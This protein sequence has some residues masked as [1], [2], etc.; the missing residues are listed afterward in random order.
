MISKT[1][2][3][4]L[5]Y[6][7][8]DWKSAE[9]FI[10]E[11]FWAHST[12]YMTAGDTGL[13]TCTGKAYFTAKVASY[14]QLSK[15]AAGYCMHM[16][17]VTVYCYVHSSICHFCSVLSE[18]VA[19]GC[20]THQWQLNSST[21]ITICVMWADIIR[22]TLS[23]TSVIWTCQSS[24]YPLVS[25]C[26]DKFLPTVKSWM[27]GRLFIHTCHYQG[28]E[29]LR[30]SIPGHFRQVLSLHNTQNHYIS[31]I[32]GL[33]SSSWHLIKTDL[34]NLVNHI[35]MQGYWL[36][37]MHG[38]SGSACLTDYGYLPQ[39]YYILRLVLAHHQVHI[40]F[41]MGMQPIVVRKEELECNICCV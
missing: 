19:R 3:T 10:M 4:A 15:W 8:V 20:I 7:F 18:S 37:T 27:S 31:L 2:F 38:Q 23:H 36:C 17:W 28:V 16:K 25:T 13:A 35:I 29:C 6:N 39:S 14:N 11:Y 41:Q 21:S 12:H 22:D 30:V 32:M 34:C 24:E 9:L 1:T 40:S 33:E 26:S 5:G